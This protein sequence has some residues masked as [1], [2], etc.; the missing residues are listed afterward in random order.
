MPTIQGAQKLIPFKTNSNIIV[1]DAEKIQGTNIFRP[2]I[3][4]CDPSLLPG[5]IVIVL[6]S[7]RSK[8]IGM[9]QMVVSANFIKNSKTGKIAELYERI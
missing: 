2:G 6:N 1:F 7:A 8:V 4:E 3:K 5:D 9:A